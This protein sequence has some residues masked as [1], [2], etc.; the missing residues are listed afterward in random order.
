MALTARGQAGGRCARAVRAR[1][2]RAKGALEIY[3]R[4]SGG[5]AAKVPAFLWHCICYSCD[6]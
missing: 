4:H 1:A 2:G 6:G 5:G 3:S